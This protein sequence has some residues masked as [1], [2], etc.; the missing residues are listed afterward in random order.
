MAPRGPWTSAFLV[1][2]GPVW[3]GTLCG[4]GYLAPGPLSHFA[5]VNSSKQCAFLLPF[6]LS[7][8]PVM[9]T[10]LQLH[11]GLV[12][13]LSTYYM[14][15][16]AC[17]SHLELSPKPCEQCSTPLLVQFQ[18]EKESQLRRLPRTTQLLSG[19]TGNKIQVLLTKRFMYF[20]WSRESSSL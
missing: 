10:L 20:T 5:Q 12:F 6:L 2:Q 4:A 17:C 15:G 11:S 7:Q 1:S 16:T 3:L 18:M 13:L 19:R 14:P 9:L 8:L